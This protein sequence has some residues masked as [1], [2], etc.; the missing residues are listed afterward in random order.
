MRDASIDW[1]AN[2]LDSRQLGDGREN[3]VGCRSRAVVNGHDAKDPAGERLKVLND[4][5]LR[6]EHDDHRD[7]IVG[8]RPA[9]AAHK[10][11]PSSGLSIAT[12][13]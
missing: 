5:A 12:I 9:Y 7:H 8:C 10:R 3:R 2:E 11:L 6:L 1:I 4:I 13:A